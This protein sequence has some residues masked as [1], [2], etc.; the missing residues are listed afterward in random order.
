M[1]RARCVQWL[2]VAQC[3]TG[4][5]QRR[6]TLASLRQIRWR[7]RNGYEGGL[8][9]THP[10]WRSNVYRIASW[11]LT[12]PQRVAR[13]AGSYDHGYAAPAPVQILAAEVLRI[14]IGG[15]PQQS[16]GWPVCGARF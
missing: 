4:G 12:R 16:A 6:V 2:Q 11:R 10:T 13:R 15:N 3:E 7:I 8:Q 1:T 14:R 9:F 5:Q